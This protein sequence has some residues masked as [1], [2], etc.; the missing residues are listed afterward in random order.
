MKFLKREK[1]RLTTL[2]RQIMKW[3]KMEGGGCLP[4]DRLFTT[5]VK[6]HYSPDANEE[7]LSQRMCEAVENLVRM[8]YAEV[9]LENRTKDRKLPSLFDFAPLGGHM[10]SDGEKFSWIKGECPV[11]ALSDAGSRYADTL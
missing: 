6:N 3:L 11:I 9:R 1:H 4:A 7:L 8:E 10:Q 2:Q 5:M